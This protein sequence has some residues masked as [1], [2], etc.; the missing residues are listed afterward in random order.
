M[1]KSKYNTKNWKSVPRVCGQCGESFLARQSAINIGKAKYCT[2][3]CYRRFQ[4]GSV[5]QRFINRIEKTDNC[6]LWKGKP[7]EQGYGRI[8]GGPDLYAHRFSYILHKGPIPA[9]LEVCH[10]CDTRLC[11]NPD[12]L[13]LGTH[14][15]NMA[16]M[17]AKGRGATGARNGRHTYPENSPR[18]NEHW[19]NKYPERLRGTNNTHAKLTEEQVHSIRARYAAGGISQPALAREMGVKPAAI[20]K[21]I[22]HLSWAHL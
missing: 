6:W 5:E 11:V 21:I 3:R 10:S 20:Y 13:F 16:D 2:H 22:H 17:A 14:Q 15:E 9:G 1:V 4:F 12:H 19:T 8:R 18:G 7:T